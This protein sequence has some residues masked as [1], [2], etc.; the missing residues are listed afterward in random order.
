M[1]CCLCNA[2]GE[3][4]TPF[5][6]GAAF[7]LCRRHFN[8]FVHTTE[9]IGMWAWCKRATAAWIIVREDDTMVCEPCYADGIYEGPMPAH[10][11]A[12]ARIDSG[13]CE[14]CGIVVD[15]GRLVASSG[16][17]VIA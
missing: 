6:D 3:V 4:C 5:I 10:R 11:E 12:H 9:D 13:V 2:P 16:E 1:I 15:A 17:F 7:S 14:S 8:L